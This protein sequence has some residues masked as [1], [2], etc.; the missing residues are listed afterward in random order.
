MTVG[1]DSL[2]G[3]SGW[4]KGRGVTM[5]IDGLGGRGGWSGG[6]NPWCIHDLGGMVDGARGIVHLA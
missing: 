1:I 6:R 5:G 2:G 4:S 3:C